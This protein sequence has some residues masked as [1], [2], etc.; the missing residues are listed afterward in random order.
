MT[1]DDLLRE[2]ASLAEAFSQLGARVSKAAKELQQSGVPPAERLVVEFAAAQQDFAGLR[3]RVLELIESRTSSSPPQVTSLKDLE[4]SL[5]GM[6]EAEE[7]R[8]PA[9]D[10]RQGALMILDRVLA[11]AYEDQRT[12]PPLRVCQAKAR[13]LRRAI[14]ETGRVELPPGTE[15]LAE[16]RHPFVALLTLID[17]REE[18]D[19]RQWELLQN[20]VI[21]SFGKPL[22][23]AASRGKLAIQTESL[24]GTAQLRREPHGPGPALE[25]HSQGVVEGEGKASHDV[26]IEQQVT[27]TVVSKPV[28]ASPP[29]APPVGTLKRLSSMVARAIRRADRAASE[30][31]IASAPA[32]PPGSPL[33]VQ[34]PEPLPLDEVDPFPLAECSALYRSGRYQDLIVLAEPHLQRAAEKAARTPRRSREL[35]ELWGLLGRSRQALGEEERAQAAFE[36]A[37]STAPEPDQ[38]TYRRHLAELAASAA[39]RLVESVETTPGGRLGVPQNEHL[40]TLRL[41]IGWLR[42][43]LKAMPGDKILTA[44]LARARS[45]LWTTYGQLSTTLAE[46]GEIRAAGQII[47]EALAE[48]SLPPNRRRAF[49]DLLVTTHKTEIEHLATHAIR[50]MEEAREREAL[51]ALHQA[52]DLFLGIPAEALPQARR[53]E[54]GQSLW[55]GYTKLGLRRMESGEFESAVE[56]LLQALK[57]GPRDPERQRRTRQ[58]VVSA[59]EAVADRHVAVIGQLVGAG[60]HEA[61]AAQRERLRAMIHD[62]LE[63]G[64]T[65]KELAVAVSRARHTVGQIGHGPRRTS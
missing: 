20:T 6:D 14:S 12:Y 4:S 40:G 24:S 21:E 48:E 10:V 9:E 59:L 39:R 7:R 18:L 53:K 63:A 51:D 23:V 2:I 5:R 1:R 57:I 62:A 8:V 27:D 17:R 41:A 15:A 54:I 28:V 52:E 44:S 13:G 37:I 42:Q 31:A 33:Q 60:K 36:K 16:G 56:P 34:E 43:G 38:A 50:I 35:A 29:A 32:A 11:L 65:E 25:R 64:L 19:D 61:V 47:Q 49:E 30:P 22:A 3:A 45:G 55:W 26:P 46:R 58:A